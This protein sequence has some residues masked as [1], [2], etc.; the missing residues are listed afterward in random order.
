MPKQFRKIASFLTVLGLLASFSISTTNVYAESSKSQINTQE[1]L[2]EV[3]DSMSKNRGLLRIQDSSDLEELLL[4]IDWGFDFDNEYY[5]EEEENGF[6]YVIN[7]RNEAIITGFDGGVS[8]LVIP[9]TLGGQPVKMIYYA[10]FSEFSEITSVTIQSGVEVIGASAFADCENLKKV[11]IPSSVKTIDTLAFALD[12]SLNNVTVPNS[13][14]NFGAG[15]FMLNSS[16]TNVTL[17]SSINTIPDSTF[18]GCES[19]SSIKIPSSVKTIGD[20]AFAMTGF[21]KFT[22]PDG[23]TTIG[24]EAFS[25]C[26]KLTD[27]TIP[28][29][30]TKIGKSLVDA[31]AEVVTIHGETGSYAETYAKQNGLEFKSTGKTD[32]EKVIATGVTTENLNVRKGAGANYARIG[33]LTK[34]AKVEIVKKESNGWYKIKYNNGYGYV[35]GTYVKLDSQTPGENPDEEKVIAT[36]VTTENLNVRKGAGAN[37]AR[38]GGLTKGA[39]V[40]IVKK[41]SNGW[42]KIKYNNAYGYVSG[43]YVK[44]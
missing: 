20:S 21:T 40:E 28:K 8:N 15:V 23:V 3:S 5:D 22:V 27:L 7:D 12:T 31:G 44:L 29:S 41:E 10:A 37:Y 30:V 4:N 11:T 9:S 14:G 2:N 34:G 38:I 32:D 42:Y 6:Y 35:S 26:E 24:D 36:G 43:T 25:D 19:L 33:G 1:I 39:K 13:V 18:A 16:L 17:P